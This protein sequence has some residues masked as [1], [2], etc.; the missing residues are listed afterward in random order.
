M[1]PGTR[2]D[3]ARGQCARG[4]RAAAMLLGVVAVTA[5]GAAPPQPTGDVEDWLRLLREH[6]VGALD[7]AARQISGW[8]WPRLQ[9]V[10]NELRQRAQPAVVLRSAA[11]LSDIAFE[12]PS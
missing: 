10:L 9:P 11:L 3:R 2:L 7:G 4:L 6:Q 8:D 12:I 1:R 5:W